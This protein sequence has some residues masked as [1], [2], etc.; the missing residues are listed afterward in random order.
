MTAFEDALLAHNDQAVRLLMQYN[1]DVKALR[2]HKLLHEL[3]KDVNDEPAEPDKRLDQFVAGASRKIQPA[4][5]TASVQ[6]SP[7][8][9]R[10]LFSDGR[11]GESCSEVRRFLQ[12]TDE[13]STAKIFSFL[14]MMDIV[15]YQVSA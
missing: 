1:A 11:R 14:R 7:K 15:A 5:S 9:R 12:Q 13:E 10:F 6:E 8:R 2:V 4:T 3:V